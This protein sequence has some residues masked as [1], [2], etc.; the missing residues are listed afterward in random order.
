MVRSISF[1]CAISVGGAERPVS[2]LLLVST[3]FDNFYLSYCLSERVTY[4]I[5]TLN[6]IRPRSLANL[7]RYQ[8]DQPR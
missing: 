8:Q 6:L 2:A 4:H 3:Q 1:Y 5:T 7:C